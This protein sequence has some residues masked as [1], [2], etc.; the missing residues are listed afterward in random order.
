[1]LKVLER[2]GIQAMKQQKEIKRKQL[3]KKNNR[4]YYSI[5][6]PKNSTRELIKLMSNFREVARYKISS[7]KSVAFLYINDNLAE[8]E[9]RETTPFTKIKKYKISWSNTNQTSERSE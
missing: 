8:K 3:A 6:K 1:M 2:S 9:I 5:H 4:C 7:N